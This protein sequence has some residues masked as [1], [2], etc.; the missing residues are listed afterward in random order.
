MQPII[1]LK[2]ELICNYCEVTVLV[3]LD[4]LVQ[5]DGTFLRQK[6]QLQSFHNSF[7]AVLVTDTIRQPSGNE[8]F[9]P[10]SGD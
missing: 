8:Y 10:F 6:E 7:T 5:P 9:I 2:T 1:A 3:E 4:M